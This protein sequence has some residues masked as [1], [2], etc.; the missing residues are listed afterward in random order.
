M[1]KIKENCACAIIV[2]LLIMILG[3]EN[4]QP[5]YA[6]ERSDEQTIVLTTENMTKYGTIERHFVDQEGNENTIRIIEVPSKERASSRTFNVWFNGGAINCN[7]YMKVSNN[8]CVSAYDYKIVTVGCTYSNAKLTRTSK[9]AK[10]S[11]D[12]TALKGIAKG[13]CWL[14]GTVTG[15]KNDIKVTYSF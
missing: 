9:Q 8:K 13:N 12:I 11:M 5:V 2:A 7:F 10:L 1:S 6:A 15:S 4:S 3:V 14:K